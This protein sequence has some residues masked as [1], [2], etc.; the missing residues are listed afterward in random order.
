MASPNFGTLS[1]SNHVNHWW[2]ETHVF[3]Y[4]VPWTKERWRPSSLQALAGWKNPP[5]VVLFPKNYVIPLSGIHGFWGPWILDPQRHKKKTETQEGEGGLLVH[6]KKTRI[7]RI[8]QHTPQTYPRLA[9]NSLWFFEFRNHLWV[10]GECL[11]YFFPGGMLGFEIRHGIHKIFGRSSISIQ[12]VLFSL[13]GW[14]A[15][16]W[17]YGSEE[18]KSFFKRDSACIWVF[19]KIGVPQMDGL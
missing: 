15:K 13:G 17:K 6:Q 3:R 10:K 5:W 16:I 8:L 7:Q 14:E 1:A 19:P 2:W 4:L 12:E 9:S 11:G 18:V